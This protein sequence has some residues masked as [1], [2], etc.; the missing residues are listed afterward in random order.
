[1]LTCNQ[2]LRHVDPVLGR[3]FQLNPN[4]RSKVTKL[5]SQ[6]EKS[7]KTEISKN[8]VYISTFVYLV[9]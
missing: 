4:V 1:M 6:N 2:V 3:T 9:F 7:M 8:D 5:V